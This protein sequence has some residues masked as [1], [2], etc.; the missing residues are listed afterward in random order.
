MPL[1]GGGK[2]RKSYLHATDLSRAIL[3]V[4]DRGLEGEIYN[5]GPGSTTLIKQVVSL[6]ATALGK[7]FEE[8]VKEAPERTGQDSTY[9]LDSS[10][11]KNLGWRQEIEWGEGLDGMV[12]W[13]NKYPELLTMDT[14]F[15]MR[16]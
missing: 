11:V 12:E 10:K 8:L 2:A 14:D 7:S 15:R 13:I 5:V 16:A 1:H 6:C 3:R 9:W 4:I